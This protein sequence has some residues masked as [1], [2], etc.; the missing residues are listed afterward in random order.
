VFCLKPDKKTVLFSPVGGTDPISNCRDGSILHICRKYKPD[1]VMLYLSG[2]MLEYQQS[3]DRYRRSLNMLADEVGFQPVI[4]SEERPNLMDPHLFDV[5]YSDFERCL[6]KLHE[7]YP[8]HRL[9]VNLS[10]GTPAMKSALAVLTLL[11]GLQVQGIQVATPRHKHN[12]Q[13]ESLDSYDVNLFWEYNLDRDVNEY[14]DRCSEMQQENLRGKL[15][16]EILEAHL[17][18]YDYPAALNVAAKMNGLLPEAASQ[19][20]HAAA[21]RVQGEWRKI[22]RPMQAQL[23]SGTI[24]E[25][26][27]LFE[28]LLVLQIR[29]K[30][31]E[32][33]DFL[34]GLTPILYGLSMFELK[35]QTN[36]DL[37]NA[38]DK[39]GKIN[40]KNVPQTI[41][42]KLDAS[43]GGKC[44]AKYPSSDMCCKLLTDMAPSSPCVQE[45]NDLREIEFKLRNIAAH[46]LKPITEETIQAQ[47][48]A[49]FAKRQ[50]SETKWNSAAILNLLKKCAEKILAPEV[51]CW[52]AYDRMNEQILKALRPDDQ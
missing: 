22:P 24:G 1:C 42:S 9:L 52:N 8:D 39:N 18:A 49:I 6:L 36:I 21:L 17:K 2:E 38:C 45:L 25:K 37:Q 26:V 12:G 50:S 47:C 10:S 30:G 44:E 14:Q 32:L 33:A 29:Q 23:I 3:D 5:F 15:L 11:V 13:R 48:Q 19:L 31:G 7:A 27:D 28:Y 46:T 20:L 41:V 51:L 43:Y 35:K 34:R 40:W 16:R 4:L